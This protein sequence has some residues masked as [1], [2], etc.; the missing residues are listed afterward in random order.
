MWTRPDLKAAGKTAMNRNY[1]RTVLV[2]LVLMLV[3]SSIGSDGS[4]LNTYTSTYKDI[5]NGDYSPLGIEGF[6]SQLTLAGLSTAISVFA[7]AAVIALSVFLFRP[8]EVGGKRFMYN[9]L[10]APAD[11][12]ELGFAFNSGYYGN[13]VET[14]FFR[15]LYVFLWT[16]LFIIPGIIKAYEYRMIPYLLAEDPS[17]DRREAFRISSAMMYGQKWD[18]FVLDLS[19]LG[20]DILALITFGILDIFYVSPYHSMTSAALYATLKNERASGYYGG[21][22]GNT[23]WQYGSEQTGYGQPGNGQTGYGQPGNGQ[24]GYGAPNDGGQYGQ[25]GGQY[26]QYGQNDGVQNGGM[27]NGGQYDDQGR[28]VDDREIVEFPRDPGQE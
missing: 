14:M 18:T 21:Q 9:N 6:F 3:T 28:P 1:W 24:T 27:Q 22:G 11:P 25:N 2:A 20:W 10:F 8:L 16:L 23:S 4:S 17:M 7:L 26:G 15:D 5:F 19:F 13:I 12:G